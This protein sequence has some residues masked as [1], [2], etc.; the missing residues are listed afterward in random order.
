MNIWKYCYGFFILESLAGWAIVSSYPKISHEE[1]NTTL[2]VLLL[3]LSFFSSAVGSARFVAIGG[4]FNRISD[5]DLGGS[6]LTALNSFSNLG[7]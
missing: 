1:D 7:G 3:L 5:E 4:F 6:S 2:V